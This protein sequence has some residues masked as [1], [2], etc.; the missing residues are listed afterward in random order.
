MSEKKKELQLFNMESDILIPRPNHGMIDYYREEIE[1]LQAELKDRHKEITEMYEKL[2]KYRVIHLEKF[3]AFFMLD[4]IVFNTTL[5][6][7]QCRNKIAE[8]RCLFSETCQPR[9]DLIEKL[10]LDTE[11]DRPGSQP[12][13]RDSPIH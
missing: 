4:C 6:L 1:K 11:D 13:R 12:P 9:K 8:G 10:H 5:D 3:R 2:N 7:I